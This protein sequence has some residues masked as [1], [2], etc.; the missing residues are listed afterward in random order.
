MTGN[1][2]LTEA[3]PSLAA[4]H[5]TVS[6]A[7]LA[8]L[9]AA[10][11]TAESFVVTPAPF[12]RLGLAN[13][14]V[15]VA[16]WRWGARAALTVVLVKVIASAVVLGTLFSPIIAMNGGGALVSWAVMTAAGYLVQWRPGVIVAAS[17]VAGGFHAAWQV[18]FVSFIAGTPLG[19][20]LIGAFLP[21]SV[22]AGAA[23]GVIAKRVL[24]HS[25]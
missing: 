25:I 23:V 20:I 2:L 24:K 12:L 4:L 13:V 7:T 6:V 10:V 11:A 14:F 19:I 5:R 16:L 22:A 9:A 3:N 21:W 17:A 15:V 8:S 18:A 1:Y